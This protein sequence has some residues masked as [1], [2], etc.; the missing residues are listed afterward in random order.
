MLKSLG[1]EV[2][3]VEEQMKHNPMFSTVKSPNRE[4]FDSLKTM[5]N[6]AKPVGVEVVIGIDPDADRMSIA[7]RNKSGKFEKF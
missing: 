5:M 6:K 3:R 1:I 7:A 2:V 4:K